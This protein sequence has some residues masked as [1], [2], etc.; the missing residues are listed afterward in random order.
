MTRSESVIEHIIRT[1]RHFWKCVE[2]YIPPAVDASESAGKALQALYPEQ[3]PLLTEDFTDNEIANQ[4]FNELLEE[5]RNIEAHQQLFDELKHRLQMLIKDAEQVVFIGGSITWKKKA[6]DSIGLDSK[7]L[8]KQHPEYLQ[9]F[10]QT[11][12]G[13]QRFQIYPNSD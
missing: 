7:A 11:K 9:Q 13:T 12:V 8:L 6:Q 5:K 3:T 1:E 10:P 2:M 4:L